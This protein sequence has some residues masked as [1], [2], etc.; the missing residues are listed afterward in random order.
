MDDPQV[1]VGIVAGVVAL[2]AYFFIFRKPS[3]LLPLDDYIPLTLIRKDVLSHD[4]RRFTFALPSS[5][6]VLG[7]PIGQHVSLKYTNSEGKA[8]Q[9][10]YTPVS[11][12]LTLGEFSLVIKVYRPNEKFPKGGLMSQHLDDLTVEQDTILVKGP[13]GHLTFGSK[14][15][16]TVK[17]LGKP[18][19][20]RSCQNIGMIAGGTGITPMLQILHEIFRSKQNVHCKLLYANQTPDDILVREELEAL[21]KEYP[22]KF[23]LWYT[24]DRPDK[25]WKYSEGFINKDMI[26]EHLTF[27]S[28]KTQYF[29]CGVSGFLEL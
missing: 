9:R 23:S 18:L 19:Q 10:S 29:M 4:T 27:S 22:E 5:K 6:Q 24:V 2:F 16:F 26:E 11:D 3:T 7:L 13:K 21:A 8:V 25:G 15:N 1:I 20:A 17:P 28:G 14:G 12:N